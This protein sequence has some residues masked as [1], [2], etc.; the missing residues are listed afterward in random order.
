MSRVA[1]INF[2]RELGIEWKLASVMFPC[3]YSRKDGIV[4]KTQDG[5][6]VVQEFGRKDKLVAV[7]VGHE[8]E[9]WGYDRLLIYLINKESARN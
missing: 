3:L 4:L 2:L 6:M 1:F 5:Y 9:L 7:K 8:E